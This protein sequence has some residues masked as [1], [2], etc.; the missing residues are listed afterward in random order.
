MA[1][2]RRN[3]KINNA[4]IYLKD[5]N[6]VGIAEEIDLPKIEWRLV[7]HETLGQVAVFK[8]PSRVMEAMEGSITFSH[9][10]PDLALD[11]YDPT[12][13]HV[14]QAH[15]KTDVTG[16]DGFDADRSFTLVT[17][18]N[19]QFYSV[20]LSGSKLGD[21]VNVPLE[22]TVSRLVQRVHDADDVLFEVDV[23]T[24]TVRNS[25]GDLWK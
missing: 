2:L 9:V 12:K 4:E 3:A 23:F 6:L 22:Y 13:T 7:E 21:L 10:E 18:L 20:S 5:N 19:V 25:S 24:N 14:L 8:T 15:H 11:F 16:P 1:D 17:V